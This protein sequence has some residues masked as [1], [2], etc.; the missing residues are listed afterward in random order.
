MIDNRFY[1]KGNYVCLPTSHNPKVVLATKDK[2]I[3]KN[4]FKLY[5][6]FSTKAKVLKAL[7]S[8][9]FITAN[10]SANKIF[11]L[12]ISKTSDF[13]E[14]LEEKL[15][16][17]LIP[18]IYYATEKEKVVLQLQ[19][20]N[21]IIGYVKFSLNE[22]GNKRLKK[23]NEA[24][25]ILSGIHLVDP[26]ILFDEYKGHTCLLLKELKGKINTIKYNELED[27]LGHFKKASKYQLKDHPRVMQLISAVKKKGFQECEMILNN[28]CKVS[29]EWYCEVFE[30]GDIAPWNLMRTDTGIVPFD[31]EYFEERGIEYFDLINYYYQQGRHLKRKKGRA[32]IRYMKNQIKIS[33]ATLFMQLFMIKEIVESHDANKSYKTEQKLLRILNEV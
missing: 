5:N 18:S 2:I 6:P 30:H 33:E 19:S 15:K 25:E 21:E 9:F 28:T 26:V 11:S 22:L 12:K 31:F 10:K 24:I 16:V 29:H 7:A 27:L 20:N 23:E 17:S 1:S 13:I 4:A 32:L 8:F 3:A 14:Y